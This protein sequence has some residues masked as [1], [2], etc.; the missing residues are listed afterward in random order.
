[1]RIL[2]L[3]CVAIGLSGCVPARSVESAASTRA[4]PPSQSIPAADATL[5]RAAERMIRAA[6]GTLAPVYAPLAEQ[7][8]ED[9]D[10]A[11][12]QGV[13]ID[14]GS[15][16][17]TLIVELCPRT[18]LHWINAD[19]NPWFFPYFH[20]LA[21]ARGVGHRVSAVIADATA[22]PFRDNYADVVVS[23]GSY[24]FWP[25]RRKG[26]AE[27]YRVLK[28]GGVAYIGRGFSRNLPI[29]TARE[30]RA[31]QR[32]RR[33]YDPQAEADALR[34]LLAELGIRDV[35]IHQPQPPGAGDV[36]YGLWVE[37]LKPR[38]AAP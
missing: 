11:G 22:L 9:L 2:L 33:G 12:K 15:G 17:G 19:I 32:K 37:F 18:G 7:L 38:E 28:P 26:F 16:P 23:R 14:L 27:V 4:A 34:K 6:E 10:L 8:V 13:G 3:A 25:D 36:N 20:R 29:E 35:R 31:R 24:H 21:E 30:V 5:K 1:M